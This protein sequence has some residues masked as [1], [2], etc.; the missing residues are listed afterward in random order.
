MVVKKERLRLGELIKAG[1]KKAGLTAEE[2]AKKAGIDRTYLSKIE[3]HGFL[4][5]PKV[6]KDIIAHL[7]DRSPYLYFNVYQKLK[8]REVDKFF[9]AYTEVYHKNRGNL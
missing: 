2:L 3:R 7:R 8:Y 6:L 4:P 5:S 1:R 9:S